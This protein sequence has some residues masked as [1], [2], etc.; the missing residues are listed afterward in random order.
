MLQVTE[1]FLKQLGSRP[2]ATAQGDLEKLMSALGEGATA[3]SLAAGIELQ[4]DSTD[5]LARL[6]QLLSEIQVADAVMKLDLGPDVGKTL[7]LLGGEGRGSG[8]CGGGKWREAWRRHERW[9]SRSVQGAV[10]HVG[11]CA[12]IHGLCRPRYRWL[13]LL[14]APWQSFVEVGSRGGHV[15]AKHNRACG[16]VVLPVSDSLLARQ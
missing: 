2:L 10:L 16:C 15:A 6:G 1:E 13:M 9:S 8:C 3:A 4:P 5:S 12:G 11:W 14:E 7:D